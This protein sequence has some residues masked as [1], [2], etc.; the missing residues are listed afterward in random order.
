MLQTNSSNEG[1]GKKDGFELTSSERTFLRDPLF[2]RLR[3]SKLVEWSFAY[4]AG[5]WLLL[6]AMDIFSDVWAWPLEI[7]KAITILVAVGL[8]PTIAVA[9]FRDT[10]GRRWTWA[11]ASIADMLVIGLILFVIALAVKGMEQLS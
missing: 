10:Q 2:Q 5:A 1:D 8:I 11:K 3:R 6:Q 4:L 7:Q 9:W